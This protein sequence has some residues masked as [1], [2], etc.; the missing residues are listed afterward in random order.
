MPLGLYYGSVT[1]LGFGFRSLDFKVWVE[2]AGSR[3]NG[4]GVRVEGIHVSRP[5]AN[6]GILAVSQ[7]KGQLWS[8]I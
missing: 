2:G 3:V 4:F 1:G 6:P 7:N 5:P 8:I